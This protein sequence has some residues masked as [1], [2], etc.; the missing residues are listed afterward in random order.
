MGRI[1]DRFGRP[2]WT[3]A[4]KA[5][6]VEVDKIQKFHQQR[7]LKPRP[8]IFGP[9]GLPVNMNVKLVPVRRVR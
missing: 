6:Q 7:I 5:A 2:Y 1:V 9:N 3:E 4:E 8:I